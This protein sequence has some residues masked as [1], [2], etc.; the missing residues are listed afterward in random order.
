MNV[1]ELKTINFNLPGT[2]YTFSINPATLLVSWI[3]I[4]S[5]L[6]LGIWVGL[7]CRMKPGRLQTALGYIFGYFITLCKETLGEDWKRFFPLVMT[8]FLFVVFCNLAS[9]VPGV[10]SP[11]FD[12]NTCLGLGILVFVIV[13]ISA[14]THKGLIGYI[15]GYFQPF[16]I[17]FPLNVLSE[18][19]KVVSHS[20]RLF[21][22]MFAGGIIIALLGPSVFKVGGILSVPKAVTSPIIVGLLIAT[23]VFYGIF[24]GVIQAFVF[25]VLALTYIAVAREE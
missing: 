8:L 6:L 13:H 9:V 23:Q 2:Q 17:L 5:L 22:N 4:A 3:I 15:K 11:T 25:A 20:F 10:Q 1:A 19:G 21:G 24:V 7:R 14:V 16:F 12:L 18:F